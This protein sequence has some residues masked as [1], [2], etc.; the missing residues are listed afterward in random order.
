MS[1]TI[2]AADSSIPSSFS[3][4][5]VKMQVKQWSSSTSADT[6]VVVTADA[7]SR[8]DFAI[9]TGADQTAS[10]SVSNNV[11]TFAIAQLAQQRGQL[12]LLGR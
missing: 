12:I 7:L 6:A 10:V 5:P 3:L 8:V 11:A 4:G 1:V 2:S 9:L